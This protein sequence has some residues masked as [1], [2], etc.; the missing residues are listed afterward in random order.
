MT[1]PS[2][3]PGRPPA[4]WSPPSLSGVPGWPPQQAW[5]QQQPDPQHL[6]L[7]PGPPVPPGGGPRPWTM[8]AVAVGAVV[9]VAVIVTAWVLTGAFGT[10]PAVSP[11]PVPTAPVEVEGGDL[12]KVVPLTGPSGAGTV[13]VTAAR[14]TPEGELAPA[15]GTSYLVLD[16]ELAGTS[17]ELA[18]GGV[19]TVAIGTDGERRGIA[20]GPELDPLLAS[21][22]LR[23]GDTASGQL[24]FQLAPGEVTVEFQD[25]SGA[26]LGTVGLPGP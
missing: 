9:V 10:N 17:G 24:G 23:P 3:Q 1:D 20:Y 2:Q 16:V 19:F 6:V 5:P 26:V 22:V 11:S 12:G 18:V 14:W 13:T 7:P 15:D 21:T 4:G 25:P 8:V